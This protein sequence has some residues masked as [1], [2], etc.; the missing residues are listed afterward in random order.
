MFVFYYLMFLKEKKITSGNSKK[1]PKFTISKGIF[2]LMKLYGM[3][4]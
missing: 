1:N 3:S 4:H 2:M